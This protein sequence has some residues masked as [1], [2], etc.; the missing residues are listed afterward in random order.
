MIAWLWDFI[1]TNKTALIVSIIAGLI[2]ALIIFAH[3]AISQRLKEI[4]YLYRVKLR[5]CF[6]RRPYEQDIYEG[7]LWD[8]SSPEDT[9]GEPLLPLARCPLCKTQ[10]QICQ[11]HGHPHKTSYTCPKPGCRFPEKLTTKTH[12]QFA[13]KARTITEGRLQSGDYKKAKSRLK[14]AR[15]AVK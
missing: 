6:S 8:W 3:K 13:S 11:S 7:I 1:T 5:P 15:K 12:E 2:V 10:L 9:T 4:P 14:E